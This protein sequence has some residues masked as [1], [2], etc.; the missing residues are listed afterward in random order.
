MKLLLINPNA[1]KQMTDKMHEAIKS[2]VMPTTKIVAATV[3]TAPASIQGYLDI[4]RCMGGLIKKVEA[5]LDAD[6][7]LIGCF[8]DTGV[9]AIRCLTDAPVLGIGEAGYH[10]A[11][12]VA[13]KFGVV[14]TLTRSVIGL[15]ANLQKYGLAAR[16]AGVRASDVSVLALEAMEPASLNAIRAQIILSLEDDKAEAIVL[17][18]AGMTNLVR[19][20]SDEFQVPIIDGV[21]MGASMLEA[22]HHNNL[23]T[24]KYRTYITG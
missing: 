3:K 20:F 12:M 2:S 4:G 15:E 22:L 21:T 17:G 5:H 16:C 7:I 24:S 6:A 18:C 10:S 19:L 8:D 13:P 1:T 14:T 11:A 23:R 9:E